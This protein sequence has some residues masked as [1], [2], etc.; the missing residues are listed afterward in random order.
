M[1]SAIS[2]LV[3]LEQPGEMCG[4]TMFEKK[5]NGK[6]EKKPNEWEKAN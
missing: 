2:P 3:R 1:W 5:E 4:H 6:K